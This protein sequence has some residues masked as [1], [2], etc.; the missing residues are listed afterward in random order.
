MPE[1]GQVPCFSSTTRSGFECLVGG[2]PIQRNFPFEYKAPFSPADVVEEY[3]RPARLVENGREVVMPALSEPEYVNFDAIGTLEAFNTDGLRSLIRTMSHIPDMREK[4]L[5][6]PGHCALMLA[7]REAGFLSDEPITVQGKSIE[8]RQF[9]S[10]ILFDQW[11]LQPNEPELTVMRVTVEGE[12]NGKQIRHVWDLLDYTDAATGTSSMART[13]GYTCTAMAE[14]I[15]D[16][17]W[18]KAG[19]SPGEIV[20]GQEGVF[21]QIRGYL[22]QRGVQLEHQRVTL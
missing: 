4:T 1:Y 21:E 7:M 15:L 3:L 18:R 20:G 13:T 8:P 22:K 17:T 2:L 5:R 12:E 9:T 11:K 16:G 14:A 19:V 6:Y 10:A